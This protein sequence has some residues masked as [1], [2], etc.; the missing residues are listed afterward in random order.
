MSVPPAFTPAQKR[1]FAGLRKQLIAACQV[2]DVESGKIIA[3]DLKGLLLPT[4]HQIKYYEM[5]MHLCEALINKEEFATATGFL[6]VIVTNTNKSTKLYQEAN[7]LLGICKIHN[8]NLDEAEICINRAFSSKAIKN[9]EAREIFLKNVTERLEEEAL[10]TA[11]TSKKNNISSDQ[12]LEEVQYNCINNTSELDLIEKTGRAVPNS[13]IDF[14][15]NVNRMAKRQ[16]DYQERLMLPPPPGSKEY[17]KIGKRVLGILSR[18]VGPYICAPNC[19]FQRT[20]KTFEKPECI[21]SFVVAELSS[22]GIG[23]TCLVCLSTII[24]R[25][26]LKAFCSKWNLSGIMRNRY[27][28]L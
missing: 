22:Q 11:F 14:M 27:K 7:V 15:T 3:R 2:L 20:V 6:D 25:S 24:V 21:V 13:A 9:T 10:L 8:V 12:I 4:G 17:I 23:A 28:K 19:K 16:L 5:L 26:G 1:R 18:K